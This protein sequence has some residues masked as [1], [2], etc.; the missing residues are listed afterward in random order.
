MHPQ[1]FDY[2]AKRNIFFSIKESG[3]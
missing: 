1:V 3:K 2:K